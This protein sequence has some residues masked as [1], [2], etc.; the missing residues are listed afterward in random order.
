M[1]LYDEILGKFISD[2][3]NFFGN[4]EI[5]GNQ[6]EL[7]F[8]VITDEQNTV[9]RA[10]T[11]GRKFISEFEK[12]DKAMREYAAKKLTANANDW[13]ADSLEDEDENAEFEE[14]TEEDFA[15]RLILDTIIIYG[16]VYDEE[17]KFTA[18]YGDDDM[19]WG[20]SIEIMG[21]F[22]NGINFAAIC[23]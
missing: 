7:I 14:I 23:G 2:G 12:W 8:K 6:T 18:Y 9:D 22:E 17:N 3:N 16:T 11:N 4:I 1:E 19:F 13:L 10:I 20:H 21:S 5:N 15:K